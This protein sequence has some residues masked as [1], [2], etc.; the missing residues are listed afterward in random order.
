MDTDIDNDMYRGVGIGMDINAE[1]DEEFT[2]F[3]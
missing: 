3:S 1:L 2:N